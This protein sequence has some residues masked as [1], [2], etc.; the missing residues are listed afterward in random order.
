MNTTVMQEYREKSGLSYEQIAESTG[1]AKSTVSRLF[2][3]PKY[4]PTIDTVQSVMT[5]IS[6]SIDRACDMATVEVTADTDLS[7]I[8]TLATAQTKALN[9]ATAQTNRL[10]IECTSKTKT[11]RTMLIFSMLFNVAFVT[12]ILG[13]VIYDVTHPTIGFVQY[14]AS[15][16]PNLSTSTWHAITLWLRDTFHL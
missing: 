2:T 11:Y 6:G 8:L 7:E 9:L 15:L 3:D 4:N 12:F 16:V 13:F 5:L 1:L 10:Y 14:T